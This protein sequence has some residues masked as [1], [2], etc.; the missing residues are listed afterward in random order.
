MPD[1]ERD[2]F[3]I[4]NEEHGAL[5][6]LGWNSGFGWQSEFDYF[7]IPSAGPAIFVEDDPKWMRKFLDD[8]AGI[9]KDIAKRKR[10]ARIRD[11]APEL[12]GALKEARD[13]LDDLNWGGPE[14]GARMDRIRAAIAKAE[15]AD[16]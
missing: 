3:P 15:G 8:L 4:T 1:Q 10:D 2:V 11:A 9:R 6:E 5:I 12:L 13:W 16:Q 7:H 14:N